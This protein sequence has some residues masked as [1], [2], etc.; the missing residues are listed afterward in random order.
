[1]EE[2]ISKF[3]TADYPENNQFGIPRANKK[4]PGL[5]KNKCIGN[6][7]PKFVSLEARSTPLVYKVKIQAMRPNGLESNTVE[8]TID[9]EDHQ[10]CLRGEEIIMRQ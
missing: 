8:N 4:V 2:D 1:M 10:R 3:D 9:I 7:V 5:I 6:I